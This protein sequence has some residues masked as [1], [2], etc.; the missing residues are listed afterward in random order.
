MAAQVFQGSPASVDLLRQGSVRFA[1]GAAAGDVV[2]VADAAITADSVVICYG[3]NA[4]DATAF[5]FCV[6]A[7]I[8]GT[9][10]SVRAVTA[11]AAAKIVGFAV[12]KY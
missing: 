9:G 7:V 1:A 12:L 3:L 5:G 6:D 11:V 4:G 2:T 8:A 10:F